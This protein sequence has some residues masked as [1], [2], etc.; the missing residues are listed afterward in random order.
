[1]LT[2]YDFLRASHVKRWHIVN[3]ANTQT[4]A[5]HSYLVAVIAMHLC[6][7]YGGEE[8]EVHQTAVWALFH[9]AVEIRTGDIP[10]P[11]KR[12]LREAD[13]MPEGA[14][15][16]PDLFERLDI[17][18]MPRAPFLENGEPGEMASRCV[19]M[20]DAIEAAHWIRENGLGRHAEIVS[21]GCWR[22]LEDLV[23]RN[24]QEMNIDWYRPVN[25]VLM[26]LG[27][28]YIS[29]EERITPP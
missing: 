15:L 6:A 19:K 1:M 17:V 23:A 28:P 25:E 20:A 24:T 13:R 22:R 9:D 12:L 27:M 21:A 29:R 10:T 16:G 14:D 7:A 5:E 18:L 11:A 2:L 3:T 4:I 26:A 8:A